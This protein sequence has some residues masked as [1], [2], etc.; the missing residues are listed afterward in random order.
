MRDEVAKL[1]SVTLVRQRVLYGKRAVCTC[2]EE[3]EVIDGYWTHWCS[4]TQPDQPAPAPEREAVGGGCTC[5]RVVVGMSDSGSRN[6]HDDCPMHG[7]G[8][9]WYKREGQASIE[10]QRLRAA[11]WQKLAAIV[12]ILDKPD[13]D[14]LRAVLRDRD[15]LA[16]ELAAA[17]ERSG[18]AE[19]EAGRLRVELFAARAEREQLIEDKRFWKQ[20]AAELTEATTTELAGVRSQ[21]DEYQQLYAAAE[22]TIARLRGEVEAAE[23]TFFGD[24]LWGDVQRLMDAVECHLRYH[25]RYGEGTDLET[26]WKALRDSAENARQVVQEAAARARLDAKGDE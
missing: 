1:G 10:A 19:A 13:A 21:R 6:W 24:E 9:E 4:N 5:G 3:G 11:Q 23:A 20:S 8:S 12:R 18:D 2:G 22:A 14:E 25:L 26:P 15:N 7:I 16:R 17:R